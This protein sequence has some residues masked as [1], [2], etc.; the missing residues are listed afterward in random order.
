MGT[1]QEKRKVDDCAP[2]RQ[3]GKFRIIHSL[4]TEKSV[5]TFASYLESEVLK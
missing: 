2:V 5:N 3:K 4:K 1:T